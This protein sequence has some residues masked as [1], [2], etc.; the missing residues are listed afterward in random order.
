MDGGARPQEIR[1]LDAH[2]E[3]SAPDRDPPFEL[4]AAQEHAVARERAERALRTFASHELAHVARIVPGVI[5]ERAVRTAWPVEHVVEQFEKYQG[6]Q[7]D[8]EIASLVIDLVRRGE[9][10][11]IVENDPT[12]AIYESLQ[13]RL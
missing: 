11:L 6:E 10:P 1:G 12:T 13:E 3:A 5:E 2:L 7:F 4:L 9:F 8:Q